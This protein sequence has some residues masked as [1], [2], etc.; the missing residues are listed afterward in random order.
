M[1]SEESKR[2]SA[3]F[4]STASS[5]LNDFSKKIYSDHFMECI[6]DETWLEGKEKLEE[7]TPFIINRIVKGIAYAEYKDKIVG[8]YFPNEYFISFNSILAD[9][10]FPYKVIAAKGTQ[11]LPIVKNRKDLD[12]YIDSLP[13]SIQDKEEIKISK[14]INRKGLHTLDMRT[15]RIYNLLKFRNNAEGHLLAMMAQKDPIL[16]R[17]NGVTQVIIAKVMGIFSTHLSDVI[18]NLKKKGIINGT[19]D[20]YWK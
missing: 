11:Y 3:M 13:E 6:T 1:K 20:I 8:V 4:L 12:N 15:L 18:R 16:Y 7:E 9:E 2:F 14:A 5:I 17:P 19:D 10:P